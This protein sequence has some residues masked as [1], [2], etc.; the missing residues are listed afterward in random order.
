[1]LIF[2]IILF[3]VLSALFSG[4][5]IAFI[6]ASKLRVE[7]SKKRDTLN[8]RI[9]GG[10]YEKPN[11]FISTLL[12][13]NNIA[14]ASFTL[15]F[16]IFLD[17][18]MPIAEGGFKLLIYTL[19]STVIVLIFG[20]FLPKT[21]FK[22]LADQAVYALAIPLRVIQGVLFLPSFMMSHC[23]NII[24][25]YVLRTPIEN[26]EYQ[27]TKMDLGHFIKNSS[28]ESDDEIN[29]DIF[30]KALH[31]EEQRVKSCMVPRTEIEAVDISN[32]IDDL[33]ER[34]QTTNLSRLLVTSDGDINDILGYV[35][36]QQLLKHPKNIKSILL[37][38]PFVPEAM[39]IRDLMN[40]FIKENISIACVVDEYGGTAGIVTMEDIVEEIF[41]EIEDEH[42]QEEHIETQISEHEFIF[43]GRL[44]INYL[45]EKYNLNFPEGEYTTLSG[46][47][48][49]TS[50][51]IPDKDS[52]IE[53]D[54]YKFIIE[55]V[56]DTKIDSIRVIK[57]KNQNE[58][59]DR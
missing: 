11:K 14:L 17:G 55:L 24:L 52:K 30:E 3:L 21:I 8:S 19:I 9:M 25:K 35:H 46:Y 43:S 57:P 48:V 32:T 45:N 33:L 23:S 6:S 12:V 37:D 5:E 15:L 39:R 26:V 36:H 13:G 40:R 1:M 49:M 2:L 28:K 54:G 20:E 38:I 58:E 16:E 56:G 41:G 53:L 27:I 47:L 18:S 59:L 4:T 51:T 7:L 50:E 31:L 22:H 29:T 42:D 44:E 34:L 10:F